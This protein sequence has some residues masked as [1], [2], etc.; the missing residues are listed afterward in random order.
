MRRVTSIVP[1]APF[2]PRLLS[3]LCGSVLSGSVSAA[4]IYVV[5]DEAELS[6]A[7]TA[8]NAGGE[9]GTIQLAAD[10][11]LTGPLP[12]LSTG[13]VIVGNNY[14]VDGG[15]Q[16]RVLEVGD[17]GASRILVQLIGVKMINGL[18]QGGAGDNGVGGALLVNSNADVLMNDVSIS[19]S[20]AV[21]GSGVAGGDGGD[22][23]GGGIYV[24][25]GGSISLSAKVMGNGVLAGEGDGAGLDG[26]AAGSGIFLGGSGTLVVRGRDDAGA[27]VLTDSI[28]DGYGAALS[29][30]SSTD[31]WNVV[32]QGAPIPE[33]D[34]DGNQTGNI[35]Y[36]DIYLS[37]DNQFSGDAFVQSALVHLSGSGSLGTG[38]GAVVINKG[39]LYLVDGS[40]FSKDVVMAGS[41]RFGVE[42]GES[43]TLASLLSGS[44]DVVKVGSGDLAL[45][46][47]IAVTGGDFL[48]SAGRLL[49]DADSRLGTV[50]RL[51]LSGGGLLYQ[52]AFNDIRS[53][54]IGGQ[55]GVIDGAGFDLHLHQVTGSGLLGLQ[56]GGTFTLD[57]A[58]TNSGGTLIGDNT[59]V[60]GTVGGGMLLLGLNSLYVLNNTAVTVK[61]VSGTGDIDLGSARMSINFEY[62]DAEQLQLSGDISG[63]GG[64]TKYGGGIQILTGNNMSTGGTRIYGGELRVDGDAAL[65]SGSLLISGGKLGVTDSMTLHHDITI[66]GSGEVSANTNTLVLSGDISGAGSLVLS[67]GGV[68]TLAGNNSYSGQTLVT[69]DSTLVTFSSAAALGASTLVL[70]DQGGVRLD[71]DIPDLGDVVLDGTGGV[72]NTNGHQGGMAGV[73]SGSGGLVKSGSGTL[74]VATDSLYSGSTAVNAGVLQVGAGGVNGRLGGGDIS[75]AEGAELRVNRAGVLSFSGTLSGDGALIKEGSGVLRL[76]T[77][78]LEFD[79][80]LVVRGGLVA[81][82]DDEVLGKRPVRLNGG[83]LRLEGGLSHALE[84]GAAGGILDVEYASRVADSD[85]SGSGMLTKTGAGTLVYTGAAVLD[86]GLH[87]QEGSFQLGQGLTGTVE[88]D[89]LVDDGAR[90]IFGRD[91]L[92]EFSHVISGDGD[93]IKQGDGELVITADQVF[94]GVFDI[95]QGKVRIGLGDTAGSL[96]GSA[97]LAAGA[98]LAFD[99]NDVALLGGDVTGEGVLRQQGEG[100]LLA[101][102]DLQHTGGTVISNGSLQLGNGGTSGNVT[103]S[104]DIRQ[105]GRLAVVRSDDVVLAA[106]LSG[107]GAVVI[108][109]AGAVELAGTNTYSGNTYVFDGMLTADSNQRLG[110]GNLVLDGGGFRYLSAFNDLRAIQ[111]GSNGGALDTNGHDVLFDHGISGAA[112]F[113]KHGAGILSVTDVINVQA[114]HVMAGELRVGDGGQKGILS[115]D[116]AS[117][118]GGALLT[119]DREDD[120]SLATVFSGSGNVRQSGAGTLTLTGNSTGFSGQL[121]VENGAVALNGTWGGNV[122]VGALG[123]LGGG[124]FVGGDVSA[125]SGKIAP[126][127]SIGNLTISGG[128]TLGADSLLEMEIAASGESDHLQVA[129]AAEL[130]GALKIVAL[131]GDYSAGTRYRLIDAAAVSGEFSSLQ[132]DLAFLRA[133]VQYGADHVDVV[134]QRNSTE[135]VSVSLTRNQQAVA[136][137]LDALDPAGAL[138]Q[139]VTVLDVDGAR[140]AY[141]Q[142]GGDALLAPLV[143]MQYA[144]LHFSGLMNQRASRLGLVSRGKG[145]QGGAMAGVLPGMLSSGHAVDG[146]WGEMVSVSGD[147]K[148]DKDVGSAAA[149][150]S[151]GLWVMGA[152]G[153][154]RPDLLV[155]FAVSSG[156]LQS[157]YSN[158]DASAT[159]DVQQLG[160]YSRWESGGAWHYKLSA[161][162][163]RG[164]VQATR[165]IAVTDEVARAEY[166]QTAL[167]MAVEAG[168][169]MHLGNFG[170]HPFARV[171]AISLSREALHE[172]GAALAA[173]DVDEASSQSAELALGLE[174]SR[175]WLGESGRW[176]Q[177]SGS[178]SLLQPVGDTA[179]SQSA[180]LG[181]G[182]QYVVESAPGDDAALAIAFGG[183]VYLGRGVSI[184]GGYDG[185]FGGD[186]M[187]NGAVVSALYR[188]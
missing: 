27:L 17:G 188:W 79:G 91:G 109:G 135:F 142:L 125:V 30:A 180:T 41:A 119:L 15:G 39:G 123:S 43:A 164:K 66:A 3:L 103:G 131:P 112:T 155:G 133:E 87:V 86:A 1:R 82:S 136:R 173:L 145:L 9:T 2:R 80:Q 106:N 59:K 144:A 117:V 166:S 163:G 156:S 167:S 26:V 14:S 22:G 187:M 37:A 47:S 110:A 56:G 127:N 118:D 57:Q 139:A 83:G 23:L 81:F 168:F 33:L 128:L 63:S 6:A 179:Q 61:G 64:I 99:R 97:H 138:V 111:L 101:L 72:I 24:T 40:T 148:E 107:A 38:S 4:S 16:Y 98:Q 90:L 182:G 129:G 100:I 75:I 92:N 78:P 70:T 25:P 165:R 153:Y 161:G 31:R 69:G 18:A 174:V 65:G 68:I 11:A 53:I 60:V 50:D 28:A 19:Q 151:G 55:G 29:S 176:A 95:Q 132:N 147:Q 170:F 44:G 73:F 5:S 85:I 113:T 181:Q 96:A 162:V 146:I 183:E 130:D 32:F 104:V 160:V 88:A 62:E 34:S 175:P 159:Q 172:M 120:F 54:A 35:N 51:I 71:V 45:Q 157:G 122:V 186:Y 102:G 185:R 108:G 154:W 121:E 8:I 20:S 169:G 115:A 94:T 150:T 21:G 184:W 137:A 13:A 143:D 149:T 158:R 105:G 7:I 134:M 114:V 152:D 171:S 89:V 116:T 36:S 67:G 77:T 74:L 49:L 126:G 10:V 177:V 52:S 76:Y 46:G 48:V 93:V 140:A 12:V 178:V 124:G 141:D 58:L 84:L 42:G